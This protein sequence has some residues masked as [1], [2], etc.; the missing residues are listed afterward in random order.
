M[1][2]I[3]NDDALEKVLAEASSPMYFFQ[4]ALKDEKNTD[5][6]RFYD[7]DGSVT[8]TFL[9]PIGKIEPDDEDYAGRI[10]IPK[11]KD[12]DGNPIT[13][14]SGKP[15]EP[16]DKYEAKS[17]MK[18]NEII[19]GFGGANSLLF[20]AFRDS[21]KDNKIL[22]QNL[23]GTKWKIICNPP[24]GR[25]E[26]FPTWDVEY[27]GTEEIKEEKESP[28]EVAKTDEDYDKIKDAVLE[29]KEKNKG[30][31]LAGVDE[32]DLIEAVNFI[33]K[34]DKKEIKK[35]IPELEKNDVIKKSGNKIYIQ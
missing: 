16:W 30:M 21:M 28:K 23:A 34:I 18:D 25:D 10:W 9:S 2:K 32:V 5:F 12:K 20:R 29:M 1:V 19:Y 6:K 26:R 22:N 14:R 24:T 8:V 27:L 31:I 15:R 35:V 7:E 3:L 4:R 33:S 17:I 11:L 13:D